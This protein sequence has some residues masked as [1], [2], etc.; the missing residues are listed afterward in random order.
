MKKIFIIVVLAIFVGSFSILEN[1][2]AS[3]SSSVK[4]G[5]NPGADEKLDEPAKAPDSTKKKVTKK[6]V[7][8]KRVAKKRVAKKRVAK[9]RV[10]KKRVAKKK[11]TKK[12]SSKKAAPKDSEPKDVEIK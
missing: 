7:A 10:A 9:K 3:D 4:T 6:R 11:V 8:K 12:A 5:I 1:L 2:S